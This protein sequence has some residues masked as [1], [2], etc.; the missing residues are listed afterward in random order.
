M[1]TKEIQKVEK[2]VA[3]T[4]TYNMQKPAEV[5]QMAKTLKAYVVK[6]KLYTTISGKNYAHVDG[7]QFAGFLTGLDVIVDEPKNLSVGQEIKWS[8]AAHLLD[9][10]GKVVAHGFALCSNKESKKKS[11]DEYAIMSMAQT[12][13]IGKVFRNKIGWVMK[14]AG[15]QSTPSEEMHKVDEVMKEPVSQETVVVPDGDMSKAKVCQNC[16]SIISEAEASFSQKIFKKQLCRDCQ[17]DA[18]AKK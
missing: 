9:K 17:K 11:F 10:T 14:L 8:C 4:K 5:L 18:K 3:L 12:R 1:M 16:D 15:Y 2:N 7:W 13:A 6:E